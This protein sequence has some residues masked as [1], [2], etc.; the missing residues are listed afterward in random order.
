M[1][2]EELVDSISELTG[3]EASSFPL[4]IDYVYK[5]SASHNTYQIH[6]F[7]EEDKLYFECDI[8][9]LDSDNVGEAILKSNCN[10][11]DESMAYLYL[12]DE[13]KPVLHSYMELSKSTPMSFGKRFVSFVEACETMNQRLT[14]YL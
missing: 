1:E 4:A 6:L 12:S 8:P 5:G 7:K 3:I 13:D 10:W 9:V 14:T 11:L 2:L